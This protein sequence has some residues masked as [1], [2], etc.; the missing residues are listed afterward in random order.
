LSI[1][2]ALSEEQMAQMNDSVLHLSL[3]HASKML[4]EYDSAIRYAQDA[5]RLYPEDPQPYMVLGELFEAVSK[6]QE[7]EKCCREAL[8]KTEGPDCKH[9]LNPKNVFFTLCCLTSCLVQQQRYA[10][11]EAYV[12]RAIELDGSSPLAYRHLA[13]V[14]HFQRRYDDA[15]QVCG[16]IR[17]LD[18]EDDE[19]GQ[20][21][22]AIRLDQERGS[23]YGPSAHAAASDKRS[24][25][26]GGSLPRRQRDVPGDANISADAMAAVPP[27]TIVSQAAVRHVARTMSQAGS[28]HGSRHR[29]GGG[30]DVAASER[31]SARDPDKASEE[32][33]QGGA[34]RPRKEEGWWAV[35]CFDRDH[36]DAKPQRRP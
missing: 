17:E 19:I 13:D 35:C 34:A 36:T 32:P 15:L 5:T 12:N 26:G 33:S 10:E 18:P 30:R 8:S 24:G 3:A 4:G 20:K 16:H 31:R 14:Y 27:A 2:E 1:Y 21:I 29:A 28:Q 6:H 9:S 11:A 25:S 22:E 7:A 23:E